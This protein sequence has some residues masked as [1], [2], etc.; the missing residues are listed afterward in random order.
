MDSPKTLDNLLALIDSGKEEDLEMALQLSVNLAP[1]WKWIRHYL[2]SKKR[3]PKQYVSWYAIYADMVK[4][5][6]ERVIVLEPNHILATATS[7]S[8]T[9]YEFHMSEIHQNVALEL[10][11]ELFGVT[12]RELEREAKLAK[13]EMDRAAGMP[14]Y[15]GLNVP[16]NKA[17][18]LMCRIV[19]LLPR[20][21]Y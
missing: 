7:P 17:I 2:Q 3:L 8:C 1:E 9:S 19:D 15:A 18:Q 16:K 20:R 6:N 5:D 12:H 4:Y 13:Y 14:V 21:R 11:W 10:H